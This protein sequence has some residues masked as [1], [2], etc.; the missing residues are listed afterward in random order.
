MGKLVIMSFSNLKYI[1]SF[2]GLLILSIGNPISAGHHADNKDEQIIF[3]LDLEVI[4]GK[5]N[6][7]DD[8]IDQLVENVKKTEPNTIVYEYYANSESNIFLYEV[9]KNHAAAEF[10]VD[11]FMQGPLMPIF[12]DTFKV[13]TFEVLGDTTDEL[14]EKMI[15]FTQDHRPKTDGFKR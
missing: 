12:V 11:Q 15:D 6:Q 3:L 8:L 13:I 1:G 7:V 14:K 2:L 4:D 9:Y 10:H 5:Q